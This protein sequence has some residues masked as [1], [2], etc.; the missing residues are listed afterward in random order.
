MT[1]AASKL[2]PKRKAGSERRDFVTAHS[3][4]ACRELLQL[5]C[6]GVSPDWPR[7]VLDGNRFTISRQ[8]PVSEWALVRYEQPPVVYVLGEFETVPF[9]TRVRAA[10][11]AA[12]TS[13]FM[14]EWAVAFAGRWILGVLMVLLFPLALLLSLEILVFE[15]IPLLLLAFLTVRWRATGRLPDQMLDWLHDCLYA[16]P[17]VDERSGQVP[18]WLHDVLHEPTRANAQEEKSP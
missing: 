10:L 17:Q 2:K 1:G 5:E 8:M 4:E 12:T 13:R 14:T 6:S 18:D 15:L 3:V 16:P 11:D 7:V 9:G